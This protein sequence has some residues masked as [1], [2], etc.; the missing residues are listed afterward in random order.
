MKKLHFTK[1]NYTKIKEAAE[2]IGKSVSLTLG[3]R[4]N[5]VLLQNQYGEIHSTNDGVTVA[6]DIE[7]EDKLQQVIIK[8]LKESCLKTNQIVGDGTTTTMIIATNLIINAMNQLALGQAHSVDIVKGLDIIKAKYFELL[9]KYQI[10]YDETKQDLLYKVA[11]VSSRRD[12]IATIAVDAIIKAGKGGLTNVE[13]NNN[14][15]LELKVSEG[16]TLQHGIVSEYL[17]QDK[18]NRKTEYSNVKV[19]VSTCAIECYQEGLLNINPLLIDCQE[20]GIKDLIIFCGTIDENSLIALAQAN[21]QELLNVSVVY[22]PSIGNYQQDIAEDLAIYCGAK[23]FS[24]KRSDQIIEATVESLGELDAAL[25]TPSSTV[26]IS[27]TNKNRLDAQVAALEKHLSEDQDGHTNN[28]I[29]ER[30]ANLTG[31]IATIKVGGN[32]EM[33]MK[34]TKDLVDDAIAAVK[35]SFNYGF[36]NG[37]G[38]TYYNLA[39]NIKNEV[40]EAKYKVAQDIFVS[41]LN[42]PLKTLVDNAK[43]SP[44]ESIYAAINF[45]KNAGYNFET[46]EMVDDIGKAGI[47]DPYLVA[48]LAIENAVS[49]AKMIIGAGA[50][51]VEDN[52]RLNK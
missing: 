20:K 51:N 31:A 47:Y 43:F 44:I 17:L 52:I 28:I 39:R 38:T 18:Q 27:R 22:V 16:Y 42:E 25:V 21:K 7:V 36:V 24:S 41:A 4:G 3:V 23:L 35:A 5:S 10:Q 40:Y 1:D 30:I 13:F 8:V 50:I 11:K 2:L 49:V 32:N 33:E 34:A 48:R 15:K 14:N 9:E 46:D 29:Y 12:D 19:L 26:L 45:N 6:K 37:G